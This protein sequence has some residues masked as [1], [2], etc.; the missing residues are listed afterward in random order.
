MQKETFINMSYLKREKQRGVKFF[1]LIYLSSVY[2]V[3]KA[4]V[5]LLFL[6]YFV[7]LNNL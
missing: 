3:I 6:I 5:K 1:A 7:F 2:S 4:K